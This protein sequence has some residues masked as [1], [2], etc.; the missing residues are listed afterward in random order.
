MADTTL[1]NLAD[2]EYDSSGSLSLTYAS[3]TDGD[4]AYPQ[5]PPLPIRSSLQEP[6]VNHYEYEVPDPAHLD[7]ETKNEDSND[8][9]V[10]FN[11]GSTEIHWTRVVLMAIGVLL[12]SF[13]GG[14]AGGSA[15]SNGCTCTKGTLIFATQEYVPSSCWA[16]ADG[17]NNQLNLDGLHVQLGP[18]EMIGTILNASINPEDIVIET[19]TLVEQTSFAGVVGDTNTG[20]LFPKYFK[21]SNQ[22]IAASHG[23]RQGWVV[24]PRLVSESHVVGNGVNQTRPRSVVLLPLVCQ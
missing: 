14:M 12:F 18:T 13:F 3:V 17:S 19:N 20:V 11:T 1:Y 9:P 15:L 2:Q 6:G 16:P 10:E 22:S 24:Q 8:P 21:L 23:S 4:P 7:Y 5:A